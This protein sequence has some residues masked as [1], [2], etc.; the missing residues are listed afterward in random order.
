M[1]AFRAFK[2]KLIISL[3]PGSGR[4]GLERKFGTNYSRMKLCGIEVV[5]SDLT[6]RYL[7]VKS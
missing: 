4:G 7:P 6:S 3:R 2:F 1:K 5:L